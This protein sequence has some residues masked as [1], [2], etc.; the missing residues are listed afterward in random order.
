[1]RFYLMTNIATLKAHQWVQKYKYHMVLAQVLKQDSKYFTLVQDMINHDV[2]VILDNGAHEGVVCNLPEYYAIV[3]QLKPQCVVLPD[4]IGAHAIE[5]R[6]RSLIFY[7]WLFHQNWPTPLIMYVPQGLCQREVVDEFLWS[8]GYFSK[9]PINFY[10]GVGDAYKF[11]YTN[12]DK[13]FAIEPEIIKVR[14]VENMLSEC[15]PGSQ[16]QIH[17][18]GGRAVASIFYST[19]A[20]IGSIDSVDPCRCALNDQTYPVKETEYERSVRPS[21]DFADQRVADLPLLK[22]S[23]K[24]FCAAYGALSE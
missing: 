4:L 2:S 21:F 17:I 14:L 19:Q 22:E 24:K 16:P 8:V 11:C 6:T 12:D 5:S 15:Y 13:D 23:I 7:D 1:M 9:Q 18:L 20:N 3:Q 10:I